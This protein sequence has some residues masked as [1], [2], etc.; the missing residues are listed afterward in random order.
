MKFVYPEFLWAFGVLLI[1]VII[2]L[3]NFRKYKT[4][5]FSSLKFIQFVDQQTR[6]TKKLKHLLVLLAR[7]LAF[8]FLVLAFA[9][10]FIPV[11]KN[12]SKGGKPVLAIYIDNSF[13]MSMKGT[14]G[15]MISEAREMARKMI[16]DASIDTRFLLVTNAMNG[17]EQ[18]VVTKLDALER[19]DKIEAS[20][21]VRNIASVIEWEKSTIKRENETNQKIGT[22]QFVIFSDFQKNSSSLKKLKS[23]TEAF[24]YPVKLTPQETSNIYVDSVWF[25]SPIQKIGETN[26]LNIRTRNASKN[27]LT[28]VELHLEIG[29]VNRDVFLDIPAE[30]KAITQVSYLEQKEGF[31]DGKVSVNDKQF[32][33]DDEYYFSY[34][35]AKKSSILIINGENSVKSV[36]LVYSLD[37]FYKV[38]EVEQSNFISDQLKGVELVFLNG[39]KEIPSGFAEDLT[40]YSKSGGTLALFPGE[41]VTAESGW[42]SFLSTLN[43]P[44][45][46]TTF[47]EGVKIK[48]INYEDNFFKPVFEKKPDNL[49]LPSVAKA[50]LSNSFNS[51]QSISLI[52]L[53][54]GNPL[55]L[56]S[57][58]S[59]NV[60][61]YTS[62]L[63][64]AYGT[65]TSNALFST[66]LLRTA[67]LSKRKTPISLTIG[68]DSKYPIYSKSKSESPIH[69]IS[70]EIDF[71]PTVEE[72][73]SITYL[74]LSGK[75]AVENLKAGTFKIVDDS[76]QGILS[77]N[78]NRNESV[79]AAYSNSEVVSLFEDQGIKNII[80]SEISEG[81]SLTKID[82]EKPYE[83]WRVFIIIA[84]IFICIEMILLKFLKN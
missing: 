34:F 26:E 13:S 44:T 17:I 6:S 40:A 81:Q 66:L 77:L 25:S 15:E 75:Q 28:N 7:I 60:F 67:E 22:Q 41:D 10:P 33:F 62:S 83:Y 72:K 20:S 19:L 2:H 73:G 32:Y 9:Q 39:A 27:D 68:S 49:N 74:S 12:K 47:T 78:Y 36:S 1:P 82:L 31:K 4:L 46:G 59:L 58:G 80:F 23:D 21:L 69:L 14:E 64:P 70:K 56:R 42:N 45:L 71:I 52:T 76:Q 50:Y 30:D 35:V 65:F 48:N 57:L 84:L 51:T 53:Q 37:N 54:N 55:Y 29:S 18:R 11:S 3:F 63:T 61:L 43:M 5:Y 38:T 8:T 16:N 79:I 24:Y